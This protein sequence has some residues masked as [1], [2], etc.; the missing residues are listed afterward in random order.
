[1]TEQKY[2]LRVNSPNRTE[3]WT[4]DGTLDDIISQ[5]ERV[6]G[7]RND[8][9]LWAEEVADDTKC[10]EC[11]EHF[12]ATRWWYWEE[13]AEKKEVFYSYRPTPDC[14]TVREFACHVLLETPPGSPA[15]FTWSTIEPL[16]EEGN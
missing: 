14:D 9:P 15:W 5:L 6:R 8:P 16:P 4:F 1:M 2:Q 13:R 7:D 12:W 11:G 10:T 3:P